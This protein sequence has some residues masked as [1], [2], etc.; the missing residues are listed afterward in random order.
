MRNHEPLIS[1]MMIINFRNML[2][3][4]LRNEYDDMNFCSGCFGE[5]VEVKCCSR[6]EQP[7]CEGCSFCLACRINIDEEENLNFF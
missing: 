1:D 2:I 4:I 7:Y 6:C 5:I 3:S